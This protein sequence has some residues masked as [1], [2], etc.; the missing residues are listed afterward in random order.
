MTD[1]FQNHRLFLKA[2][3]YRMVGEVSAAEDI[4]QEAWLRWQSSPRAKVTSIKSYLGTVVTRLCLD[5]LKS[6]RQRRETYVGSWLPEPSAHSDAF[7]SESFSLAFL[8][9]LESLNPVER[10]VFLLKHVFDF[11]H[12]EIAHTLGISDAAARQIFHR[13]K[14]R[15]DARKPRFAPSPQEHQH[16][17]EVF[18]AACQSGDAAALQQLLAADVVAW[19]DGGGKVTAALHPIMGADAVARFLVGVTKKLPEQDIDASFVDLNAT[20]ALRVRHRGAP[21]FALFIETDGQTVFSVRSILNPD[22]LTRT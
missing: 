17:L 9:V 12:S 21:L 13:A 19:S 15:I 2:L 20:P 10:A 22:K 7:D 18:M 8:H 14:E 16:L 11:S 1:E 4:V 3:A 6:A 5:F